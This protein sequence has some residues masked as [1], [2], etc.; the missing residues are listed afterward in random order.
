MAMDKLLKRLDDFRL[1][2]RISQQKLAETLGVTFV[3][4]NRWLNGHAKPNKIQAYHIEKLLR[5]KGRRK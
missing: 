3:T 2:N 5:R 1:E 4:V